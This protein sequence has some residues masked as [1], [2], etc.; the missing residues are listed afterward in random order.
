MMA[1]VRFVGGAFDG[2]TQGWNTDEE[3][4][5][6]LLMSSKLAHIRGGIHKEITT[7]FSCGVLRIGETASDE[8][9]YYQAEPGTYHYC[10]KTGSAA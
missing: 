8:C 3:L 7:P 9:L 1:N 2:L 10:G 6:E 5:E 4:P